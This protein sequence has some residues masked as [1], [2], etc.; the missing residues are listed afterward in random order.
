MDLSDFEQRVLDALVKSDPERETLQAQLAEA[1]VLN[2]DYSGVGLFT[3]LAVPESAPRLQ[4]P[5]RYIEKI[6]KLHL[7]HPDLT[8]AHE[9]PCRHARVLHVRWRLALRR[10]ALR[11]R[12]I[13]RLG[14]QVPPNKALNRTVNSSAQLT[15]GAIWRHTLVAGSGP[16]S[17]VASRL[18]P[19]R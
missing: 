6:P 11:N 1:T 3:K 17:A 14:C 2:R 4:D 15:L 19:I 12:R 10:R 18:T 16:V 13:A 7:E 8:A 5:G 9:R